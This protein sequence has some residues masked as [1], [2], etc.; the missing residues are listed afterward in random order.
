MMRLLVHT[1]K[2][3]GFVHLSLLLILALALVSSGAVLSANIKTTKEFSRK[4]EGGFVLGEGEEKEKEDGDNDEKIKIEVR[5]D[6][7]KLKYVAKN[8]EVRL[9][10]EDER[11]K[12]AK[13]EDDEREEVE[14]EIENELEN[15]KVEIRA[16]GNIQTVVKNKI[17]A[18]TKFPLSIDVST[19][20]LIVTTPAGQKVVTVLPDRAVQNMLKAKV[21]DKV[22]TV[23]GSTSEASSAQGEFEGNV[24]LE[25]R[26]GELT[27]KVRGEKTH[28]VFGILPIS[29]ETTA[30]VSADTGELVAQEQSLLSRLLAAL[31]P[32]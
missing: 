1:N 5:R 14:A 25:M 3:K 31:S 29:T 10:A 6:N 22:K 23:E 7:L 17:G 30:F 19:N 15:E 8:G 28:R 16:E 18:E 27:Y 2:E 21:M 11:G 24:K 9:E 20:Q 13:L 12:E 32:Q 4:G 26:K